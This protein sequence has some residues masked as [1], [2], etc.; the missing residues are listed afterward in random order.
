MRLTDLRGV[1][2]STI[3]ELTISSCLSADERRQASAKGARREHQQETER[4]K[5]EAVVE[6]RRLVRGRDAEPAAA[7]SSMTLDAT[8][9][10]LVTLCPDHVL[11]HP[12]SV[13]P[14][15]R[16]PAP[17]AVTRRGDCFVEGYVGPP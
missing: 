1:L 3:S 4:A 10:S 5:A 6:A 9:W 15:S 16:A 17:E 11:G 8:V 13:Q 7:R 2:S 12:V 14:A